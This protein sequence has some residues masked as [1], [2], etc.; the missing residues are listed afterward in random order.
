MRYAAA[1]LAA[2][3]AVA[4]AHAFAQQRAMVAAPARFYVTLS[5][6]ESRTGD[7][8]VSS[9]ESAITNATGIHSDFDSK[10]TAWKA[11]AGYRL[12]PWLSLE[13]DYADLGR[14]TVQTS[15]TASGVPAALTIDRKVD[16][17]GAS[18]IFSWPLAPAFAVYGRAG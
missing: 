7:A 1:L 9:T 3:A 17:W 11:G 2:T 5:G 16:G 6:G 14:A 8:L 13:L 15:L 18:A 10:D 4:H 12:L